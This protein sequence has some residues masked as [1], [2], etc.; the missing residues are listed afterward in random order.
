[1]VSGGQSGIGDQWSNGVGTGWPWKSA[2]S[3]K[4]SC[5]WGQSSLASSHQSVTQSAVSCQ[6]S[7]GSEIID[8]PVEW[9]APAGG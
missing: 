1:M 7:A 5:Q 8:L 4:V 9:F 2:V 3:W 6:Q